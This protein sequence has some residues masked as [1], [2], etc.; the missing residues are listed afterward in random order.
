M[1]VL[2]SIEVETTTL[3]ELLA[4]LDADTEITLTRGGVPVG[5]LVPPTG[6]AQPAQAPRVMGLHE[7]QGWISDDFDDELPDSFWLGED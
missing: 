2:K 7:G 4:E 3:E 6:E 5:R 1:M